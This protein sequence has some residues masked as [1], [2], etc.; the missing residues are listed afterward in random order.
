[1]LNQRYLRAMFTLLTHPRMS[2]TLSIV[3]TSW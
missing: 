1:M 3:A 2:N